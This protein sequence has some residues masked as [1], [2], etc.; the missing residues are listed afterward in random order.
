MTDPQNFV[1]CVKHGITGCVYCWPTTDTGTIR[2]PKA[3]P[4]PGGDRVRFWSPEEDEFARDLSWTDEDIAELFGRTP[5]A[6]H[7]Y[8]YNHGYVE[9]RN[10]RSLADVPRSMVRWSEEELAFAR[11]LREEGILSWDEIGNLLGRSGAAVEARLTKP[12]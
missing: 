3:L 9:K 6:V 5:H 12:E 11:S 1:E 8:R 7:L 4:R 2:L 10:E